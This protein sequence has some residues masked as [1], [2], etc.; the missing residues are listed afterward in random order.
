VPGP[1]AESQSPPAPGNSQKD[2][3][4]NGLSPPGQG[5]GRTGKAITAMILFN[6][7]NE[8]RFLSK[9]WRF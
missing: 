5:S 7:Q 9:D 2:G 8:R 6:N 1:E 3:G 4:T